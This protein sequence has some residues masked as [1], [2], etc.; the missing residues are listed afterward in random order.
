VGSLGRAEPSQAQATAAAATIIEA[1]PGFSQRKHFVWNFPG[2]ADSTAVEGGGMVLWLDLFAMDGKRSLQNS[3]VRYFA[4][5][6]ATAPHPTHHQQSQKQNPPL[7]RVRF[8]GA[9]PYL[10]ARRSLA[11][12]ITCSA[13]YWDK[14]GN[15][16]THRELTAA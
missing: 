10:L 3:A 12:T 13:H 16:R 9:K 11:S 8:R 5:S 4:T 14:P 2:F 6:P 7:G 15:A 1:S